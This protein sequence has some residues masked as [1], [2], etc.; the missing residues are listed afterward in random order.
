MRRITTLGVDV[1][2]SRT[3]GVLVDG[4]GT[5]LRSAVREHSVERPHP[6]SDSTGLPQVIPGKS[7]GAS[8]GA[9]FLTAQLAGPVSI[10]EWNPAVGT[11]LPDPAAQAGYDELYGLHRQLHTSTTAT[12]H[13]LAAR[14][15]RP[16]RT[17]TEEP[18]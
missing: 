5:V 9:A 1:G 18:R 13:A 11:R 8:F 16:P 14:E 10:E 7:I 17:T 6:G 3:K 12:V 2:T 15:H 4:E